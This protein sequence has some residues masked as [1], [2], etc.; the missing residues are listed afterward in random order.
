MVPAEEVEEAVS[1]KHADLVE[2]RGATGKGL[3]PRGGNAHND[4]AEH[5]ARQR[6]ELALVHRE[7][8]D[9]GGTVLT[10]IGLVQL[11]DTFVIS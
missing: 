5:A 1:E 4:V 2:N 6:T 9:V 7:R 11:M 10:A 3:L 8:Q